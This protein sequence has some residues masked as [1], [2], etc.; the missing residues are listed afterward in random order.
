MKFFSHCNHRTLSFPQTDK[1]S[2][3]TTVTCLSCGAKWEYDWK[4]MQQGRRLDSEPIQRCPVAL[5]RSGASN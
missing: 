4:A 2:E 5:A 3:L 1:K